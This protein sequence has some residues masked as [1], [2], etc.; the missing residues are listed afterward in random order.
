MKSD[1]FRSKA[2]LEHVVRNETVTD[3]QKVTQSKNS[4]LHEAYHGKSKFS[5]V[6]TMQK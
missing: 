2:L 6:K 1:Q 3:S 5:I 4:G